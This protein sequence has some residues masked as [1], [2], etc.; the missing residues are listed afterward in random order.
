MEVREEESVFFIKSV[1]FVFSRDE[2]EDIEL[3]AVDDR[4]L[5]VVLVEDRLEGRR[6][7]HDDDV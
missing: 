7:G 4:R 2:E 5:K 3:L 1:F 6:A